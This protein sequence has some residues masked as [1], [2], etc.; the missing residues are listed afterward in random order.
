[1]KRLWVLSLA[2]FALTSCANANVSVP[3]VGPSQIKLPIFQ[4]GETP[5]FKRIVALADG[6][7]EI[8]A[9]LGYK[10]FLVGR[11]IASTMPELMNDRYFTNKW[12]KYCHRPGL[13]Y[14]GRYSNEGS[15][16]S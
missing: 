12:D 9:S 11:D 8:V 6:S 15:C 13:L 2:V 3:N 10:E 14:L 16:N 4:S 1:M 7:A 5:K